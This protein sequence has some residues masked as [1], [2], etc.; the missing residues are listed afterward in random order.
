MDHEFIKKCLETNDDGN[1]GND[2]GGE[3]A[4]DK[5]DAVVVQDHHA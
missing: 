4:G 2:E 1:L 5:V 3:D